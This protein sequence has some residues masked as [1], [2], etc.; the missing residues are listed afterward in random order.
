MQYENIYN[1]NWADLENDVNN[2]AQKIWIWRFKY[3]L[4]VSKEWLV[5]A[6]YLANVLW[7]EVVK[8][9][10]LQPRIIGKAETVLPMVEHRFEWLVEDIKT[11]KDWLVV[12]WLSDSQTL[13]Y[14]K[15]KNQYLTTVS[16]LK[17]KDWGFSPDF[18]AREV[19]NMIIKLPYKKN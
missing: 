7:I 16:L 3:I 4:A 12:N 5:P 10:C 2:L 19:E 6:Y 14:I 17:K 11:P 18:F 1:Y 9:L 15:N 8:T 13:E